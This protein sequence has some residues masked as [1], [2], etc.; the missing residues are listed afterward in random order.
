MMIIIGLKYLPLDSW[1][2]I[3]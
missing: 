2:L 1:S 3:F